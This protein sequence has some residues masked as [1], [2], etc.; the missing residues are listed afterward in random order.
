MLVI[1]FV[2]QH[3]DDLHRALHLLG[4]LDH[5]VDRGFTWNIFFVLVIG[6]SFQ[7]KYSGRMVVAPLVNKMKEDFGTFLNLITFAHDEKPSSSMT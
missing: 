5:G 6:A 4:R 7:A 3:D 2:F 1:S